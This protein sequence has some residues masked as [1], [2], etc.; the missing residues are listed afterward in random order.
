MALLLLQIA[1]KGLNISHK[2]SIKN[3]EVNAKE[4]NH[5]NIDMKSGKAF[6]SCSSET[7]AC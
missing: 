4:S 6:D 3:L 5:S 7:R 2:T 1:A